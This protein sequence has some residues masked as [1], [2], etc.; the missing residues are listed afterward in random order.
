MTDLKMLSGLTEAAARKVREVRPELHVSAA[1][2]CDQVT[3]PNATQS[4]SQLEIL[5]LAQ[6][7]RTTKTDKE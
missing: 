4:V 2:Y 6:S 1:L 5:Q 7:F 3:S